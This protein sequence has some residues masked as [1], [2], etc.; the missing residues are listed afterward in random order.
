MSRNLRSIVRSLGFLTA[1]ALC[2]GLP[3][4]AQSIDTA[5]PSPVL[6]KGDLTALSR[7]LSAW[8]KL[9][10]EANDLDN[11]IEEAKTDAQRKKLR[12][13]VRDL[14]KKARKAR[15]KFMADFKKKGAKVGGL[16]KHV[17][18][19]LAIFDGCFPY[20]DLFSDGKTKKRYAA[21]SGSKK[22]GPYYLRVPRGYKAN[23]DWPLI[24]AVPPKK[25]DTYAGGD[26]VLAKAFA[27]DVGGFG[28]DYLAAGMLVEKGVDFE[29]SYDPTS[30]KE[31]DQLAERAR[32]G[33]FF[34]VLRDLFVN[35]RIDTDRVYLVAAGRSAPFVLRIASTFPDRFG[36]LVLF[37]PSDLG[38]ANPANLS[39]LPVLLVH[40]DAGKERADAFKKAVEE[41]GGSVTLLVAKRRDPVDP[42]VSAEVATW[43]GKHKRN[44]FPRRVVLEPMTDFF[45]KSYWVE[46]LEASYLSEVTPEMRPRVEVIADP[47]RNRIVVKS[48]NVTKIR[49]YYNDLIADLDKD[50][51][52][53]LNGTTKTD[54]RIRSFTTLQTLVINRGDPK[55]VFTAT[56]IYNLPLPSEENGKEKGGGEGSGG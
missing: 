39:N 46:I 33:S 10:T 44:L 12:K 23:R 43:L 2:A 31:E 18:D 4:R 5:V 26:E 49:L 30:Q 14:T 7:K 37:L 55:N 6:P 32:R 29:A 8:F 20:K 13:K 9:V 50:L 11:R 40:D 38:Q 51:T 17:G 15:E 21:T 53:I 35:F 3:A 52:L 48:R 1:L 45:R 25:G 16:L 24:F 54:R 47:E 19:L 28:T 27:P 56:G 41:A 36:G 22:I 42:G 34:R